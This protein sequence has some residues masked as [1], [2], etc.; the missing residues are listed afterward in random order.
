MIGR[1]GFCAD[2]VGHKILRGRTA[3]HEQPNSR[4]DGSSHQSTFAH[5]ET[6]NEAQAK[7]WALFIISLLACI[8]NFI[9]H[10]GGI[11]AYHHIAIGCADQGQWTVETYHKGGWF[12]SVGDLAIW[13]CL[14]A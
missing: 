2:I 4:C 3:T 11:V 9:D 13:R 5:P 12:T 6:K 10:P 1:C 7:T 8:R 14:C